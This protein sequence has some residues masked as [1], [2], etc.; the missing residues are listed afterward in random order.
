[1][2]TTRTAYVVLGILA[3]HDNQSGY[4]IRKTIEQSVGFFWGESYGQLYP[5][6]KRLLGEGLI[7]ADAADASNRARRAYSITMAGRE[8]LKLWLAVPFRD[9]PPRDEFLL[10][11]FFG[12][13]A[14]PGISV[15]HIRAF[16]QK[17]R[18]LLDSML[19]LESLARAHN[20]HQPGFPYWMLTLSYGLGQLKAALAWGESTLGTLEANQQPK[21]ES[22]AE[23]ASAA[24]TN[25]AGEPQPSKGS[26]RGT[27]C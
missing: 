16:Q 18:R 9:D 5:T 12:E 23:T 24:E 15:G 17:S 8:C 3:I 19:A 10:K 11:L 2:E 25:E 13:Q 20:A 6:L 27:Q 14:A 1:M 22:A 26:K 7:T 4:E 21:V